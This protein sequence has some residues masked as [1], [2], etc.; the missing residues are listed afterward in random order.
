VALLFA[1]VRGGGVR[2]SAADATALPWRGTVR[3][4]VTGAS[5]P[6]TKLFKR[7]GAAPRPVPDDPD[8]QYN[9]LGLGHVCFAV[10]DLEASLDRLVSLCAAMRLPP[11]PYPRCPEMTAVVP[12]R[13]R[14][15]PRRASEP[16]LRAIAPRAPG[17]SPSQQ[18]RR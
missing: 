12:R 11:I 18:K 8:G 16:Q 6:G 7:D 9:V 4:G 3:V 17:A 10:N 1:A 13:P 15:Q 5:T 2:V 14:G